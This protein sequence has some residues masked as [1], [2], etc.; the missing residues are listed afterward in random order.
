[1]ELVA[2]MMRLLKSHLDQLEYLGVEIKNDE[3]AQGVLHHHDLSAVLGFVEERYVYD[4]CLQF[5]AK[6]LRALDIKK[7]QNIAQIIVKIQ[8]VMNQY[9]AS[10]T[11]NELN[12]KKLN[13]YLPNM[14]LHL[15]HQQFLK[16]LKLRFH[17]DIDLCDDLCH[18][19][20]LF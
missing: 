2:A 20:V 18:K 16:L 11:A 19:F 9:N 14:M 12:E 13:L 15:S 3:D 6:I 4:R 1:M 7:S 8:Q 17:D 10:L 5:K